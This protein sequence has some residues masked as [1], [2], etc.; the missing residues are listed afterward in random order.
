MYYYT[1]LL[2]K[3]EKL[4]ISQRYELERHKNNVKTKYYWDWQYRPVTG[5]QEVMVEKLH[6]QGLPELEPVHD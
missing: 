6:V 2:D 1:K 3:V 5:T 4:I